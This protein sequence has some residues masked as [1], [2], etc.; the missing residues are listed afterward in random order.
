M[1]NYKFDRIST[2]L[3]IETSKIDL[4]VIIT[5]RMVFSSHCTERKFTAHD[6]LTEP[7]EKSTNNFGNN[8]GASTTENDNIETQCARRHTD[9]R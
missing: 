3:Y 1:Q 4:T 9:P 2:C 5:T 6:I 8:T 7:I